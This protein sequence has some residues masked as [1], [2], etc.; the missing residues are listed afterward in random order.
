MQGAQFVATSTVAESQTLSFPMSLHSI[1]NNNDNQDMVSMGTNSALLTSKVIENTY[2]VLAVQFL[3]VI[4]AIDYLD[5]EDKMSTYSKNIYRRLRNLVPVFTQDTV[6]NE[7]TIL[8]RDYMKNNH[9]SLANIQAVFADIESEI[10]LGYSPE[11]L[12]DIF[13]VAVV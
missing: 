5:I 1:P 12:E 6:M 11:A 4:Q 13:E 10:K 8:V 9:L 3:T 2:Q 7:K